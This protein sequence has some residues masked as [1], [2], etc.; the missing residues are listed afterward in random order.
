MRGSRLVTLPDFEKGVRLNEALIK[1]VTGGDQISARQMYEGLFTY[2]PQ[3]KLWLMGKNT[4]IA[5]AGRLG[6][7]SSSTPVAGT[8]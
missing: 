7:G 4:R 3:F 6:R 8:P 5:R 1:Q 2:T